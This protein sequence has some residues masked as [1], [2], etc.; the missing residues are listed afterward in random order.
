ML[1][2]LEFIKIPQ[3]PADPC[4]EEEAIFS[5]L[6][7]KKQHHDILLRARDLEK[8]VHGAKYEVINLRQM[9]EVLNTSELED[10]FKTV[11]GN[12]KVLADASLVVEKS[13]ASLELIQLMLAGS[14]AL[15]LMDRLPGGTLNIEVPKWVETSF[16]KL[17][18]VPMLF[19]LLSM[20]WMVLFISAL[21]VYKNRAV[22]KAEFGRRNVRVRVNKSIKLDPFEKFLSDR[23][24]DKQES[25]SQLASEVRRVVWRDAALQTCKNAEVHRKGGVRAVRLEALTHKQRMRQFAITQWKRFVA[26]V[27]SLKAPSTSTSIRPGGSSSNPGATASLLACQSTLIKPGT[28]VE[29]EVEYDSRYGFLLL[30]MFRFR[31]EDKVM[32]TLMTKL[33]RWARTVKELGK[34][35]HPVSPRRRLQIEE[36]VPEKPNETLQ[37]EQELMAWFAS[38]LKDHQVID[39]IELFV[40]SPT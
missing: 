25:V 35:P 13:G 33:K 40:G 20:V 11:E 22:R 38:E 26:Y 19:F 21:I 27:A 1:E 29:V 37:Y 32:E 14:F 17:V 30:V 15:A 18:D 7:L 24:L 31:V 10:I 16:A 36:A 4:E 12:T 39:N 8:L 28:P 23:E 34:S 3:K 6:D 9:A 5:Y 2:S